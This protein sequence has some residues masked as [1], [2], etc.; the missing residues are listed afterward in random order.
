MNASQ[1]FRAATAATAV[2]AAAFAVAGCG[3]HGAMPGTPGPGKGSHSIAKAT[4]AMHWPAPKKVGPNYISASTESISIQI[5][6]SQNLPIIVNNPQTGGTTNVTFNVTVGP[7]V[8]AIKAY[9]LA[10]AQGNVLSQAEVSADI[11][12][13]QANTVNA[14]LN[15]TVSAITVAIPNATPPAGTPLSQTIVVTAFDPDGNA[16][17][18][19]GDY[20]RTI[21]IS[22]DD[23]FA[24]NVSPATIT[25]PATVVTL[26]YNGNSIFGATVTV[27]ATGLGS[28]TAL[29]APATQFTEY[30]VPTARAG[31][32]RITLGPDNAF[33]FTENT[34][35]KVGRITSGG[36]VSE[37]SIPTSAA[38]PLGIAAGSDGALW[39]V[40]YRAGNVGRVTTG[41]SMFEYP[42]PSASAAPIG[43]A[44]A[45]D[46]SLMVTEFGSQKIA[47]ITTSGVVT[48]SAAI[49][50]D[51]DDIVAVGDGNSWFTMP[52]AQAVAGITP[53]LSFVTGYNIGTTMNAIAAVPSTPNILLSFPTAHAIADFSV[54]TGPLQNDFF[55]VAQTP[56]ALAAG[57]SADIWFTDATNN[58]LGHADS[59]RQVT[60]YGIPTSNAVPLSLLVAPDGSIWFTESIGNKIGHFAY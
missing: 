41:G 43:I 57:R 10:N 44:P 53:S 23:S 14:T 52:N 24:T 36:S 33:W 21:A 9:D 13:G 20:D 45:S 47:R 29:F 2:A 1:L 5:D 12:G 4:F 6:Q 49:G 31:P 15:G 48:E 22:D 38:Q 59:A 26:N 56:N 3:A 54:L 37:F 28:A 46:G 55:A 51:V 40:E 32:E 30:T 34:A 50:T 58:L 11:V 39:F 8:F 19:P 18:G 35:S 60:T 17:V 16:I 42:L 7:H 25:S 27:K